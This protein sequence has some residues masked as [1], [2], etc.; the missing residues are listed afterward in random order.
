MNGARGSNAVPDGARARPSRSGL[1]AAALASLLL[2]GCRDGGHAAAFAIEVRDTDGSHPDTFQ[3][4]WAAGAEVVSFACPEGRAGIA[5]C[6]AGG[7]ELEPGVVSRTLTIEA[8]GHAFVDVE[9]PSEA[10]PEPF[11]IELSRLAPFVASNDYVTGLEAANGLEALTELA[12][13]ASAE[14]GA[15]QQVKFYIA[16]GTEPRVFFANTRSYPRH[17]EFA[18]DVLGLP[19]SAESFAQETYQGPDRRALAGT[20]TWLVDASFPSRALQS[21]AESPLALEFF[22]SDDLTPEQARLAYRL[23]AERLS[24]LP[25]GGSERRLFYVPATRGA[26]TALE[27]E[28]IEFARR[29][30]AFAERAELYAGVTQ[31]AL[32]PAVAF[33]TLRLVPPEGLSRTVFSSRDVLLLQRL[34]NDVPLVAGTITAE[35]QT[36]LSHVNLAARARGTPNLALPGATTDPRITPLVDRLVRFEVRLDGFELREASSDEAM[37]FWQARAPSPIVPESDTTALGF[38]AFAEL[39]F[40][41]AIRVGSKA[42]NLAELRRLL[43][44]EAPDGFAVP[45]SAYDG[46]MAQNRL[47][48][49]LCAPAR[50]ACDSAYDAAAACEAAERACH[51]GAERGDT[52]YAFIDAVLGDAALALDTPL[53]AATLRVLESV[54]SQ[55]ELAPD[56]AE[57]LDQTLG[58]HFGTAQA[59]LRS[60]TNV[61]DLPGFSGAGLYT[62]VS[63]YGTGTARASSRVREVW[64][65]AWSFRAVEERALWNVDQRAVRM[66]VAVNAAVDDEV[67]NGV[68]ITRDIAR[69][70]AAGVYVNVQRGE[71]E[72]TNPTTGLPEVFSIV[73]GPGGGVDVVRQRFSSLSPNAPLLGDAEVTHLAA[74]A[75]SVQ[76]RFAELY[77]APP[78]SLALDLEFKL[79]GP[80]RRLQIKQV[81]PYAT[82]PSNAQP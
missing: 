57:A 40:E 69:P 47:R 58:E 41:D 46:Y 27:A 11:V 28:S 48:P 9:L 71:R 73:P 59:R 67:V 38:P 8:R 22:P 66:G 49:E 23:L 77:R 62:S 5:R 15:V 56:V 50:A 79:V 3:V 74:V 26:E 65:S 7:F 24:F 1:F 16:L 14:L 30:M 44:D 37:A 68:L 25:L 10:R 18:R 20:L 17:F 29:N 80:D 51:A 32:N 33:G 53:R 4:T 19:V 12:V 34:P 35:L 70:G 61:E 54:L 42:A 45:F 72:V 81:R 78:N 52:F 64:A 60:S 43:G 55:G 36:P 75:D 2:H 13:P 31:Q 6:G 82:A 39:G 76:L 63:A 21:Q